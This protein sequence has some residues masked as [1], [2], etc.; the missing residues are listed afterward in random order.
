MYEMLFSLA[1]HL[2]PRLALSTGNPSLASSQN[3][4]CCNEEILLVHD[5]MDNSE[6]AAYLVKRELG[7]LEQMSLDGNVSVGNDGFN[8]FVVNN[9]QFILVRKHT[10]GMVYEVRCSHG[11]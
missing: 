1:D 3:T 11:I 5:G 8:F 10:V 7:G 2:E 4:L 6:P 9:Q